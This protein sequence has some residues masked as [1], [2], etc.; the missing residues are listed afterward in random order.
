[1]KKT[2]AALWAVILMLACAGCG[3][4]GGGDNAGGEA[5]DSIVDASDRNADNEEENTAST[6]RLE[7]AE[8][9]VAVADGDGKDQELREKMLLFS[10]YGIE[11]QGKSFSWFNLDD[12]KLAKMDENTKASI[13]K[14]DRNLKLLVD[15]G[16]LYFNITEPLE[17]DE[18]FEIQTSTMTVGIRGTCGW[19]DA[20]LNRVYILRGAVSCA[21]EAMEL[22]MYVEPFMYAECEI[23]GTIWPDGFDPRD[24]PEFVWEELEPEF[25]EEWALSPDREDLFKESESRE[26]ESQPESSAEESTSKETAYGSGT[27]HV[28]GVRPSEYDE[29]ETDTHEFIYVD[30]DMTFAEYNDYEGKGAWGTADGYVGMPDIETQPYYGLTVEELVE[31]M[32]SQG[33][34][35]TI[36]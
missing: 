5:S 17:D 6:M 33:F 32:E 8:G 11:T 4:A 31:K 26:S 7:K 12:T 24:I 14:E 19:V 29:N 34:T 22:E 36:K 20:D 2:R 23:D 21:T 18:T 3:N 9:S 27:Y 1:M 25:F 13:V 28:V 30:G 35:V 10:G 16:R 15:S